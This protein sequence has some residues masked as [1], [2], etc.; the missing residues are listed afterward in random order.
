LQRL[1]VQESVVARDQR[2][3]SGDLHVLLGKAAELVEI[4]KRIEER[5][6]PWIP[7][8]SRIR[9]RSPSPTRRSN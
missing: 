6:G 3:V 8:A 2:V 7:A 9:Q 1:G 4:A 5:A